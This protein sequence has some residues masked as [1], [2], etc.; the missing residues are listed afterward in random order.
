MVKEA[1]GGSL[2]TFLPIVCKSATLFPDAAQLLT[3][4]LFVRSIRQLQRVR[5][6]VLRF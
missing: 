2:S 4:A 5:N 3:Y 1:L 6:S